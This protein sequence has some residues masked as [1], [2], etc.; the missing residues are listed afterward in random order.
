[1]LFVVKVPS[2]WIVCRRLWRLERSRAWA[3]SFSRVEIPGNRIAERVISCN[4]RDLT[5][6]ALL[7]GLE[8]EWLALQAG[9]T[10]DVVRKDTPALEPIYQILVARA[11]GLVPPGSPQHVI[12]RGAA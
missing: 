4:V 10:W 8:D 9:M 3:E 12:V 1:M 6:L 5:S 11:R 2:R 7:E